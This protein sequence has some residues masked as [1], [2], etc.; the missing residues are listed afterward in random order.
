MAGET[1]AIGLPRFEGY[2]IQVPI[3]A[4]QPR[5]QA[6]RFNNAG[7]ISPPRSRAAGGIDNQL[8]TTAAILHRF[9]YPFGI[10]GKVS[11]Q[12]PGK[13]RSDVTVVGHVERGSPRC[14]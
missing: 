12:R 11:I 13:L 4:A 2:A 1:P 14:L 3:S 10:E 7:V 9:A 6:P 8:D 5:G